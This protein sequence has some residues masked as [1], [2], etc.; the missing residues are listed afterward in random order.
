MEKSMQKHNN[1]DGKE[2]FFGSIKGKII[3]M[4][5]IAVVAS[6]VSGYVGM[7]SLN[8]NSSNNEMLT[9]I[10]R[11][12]LYQ[13]ENKSFD[14]SYLYFLED[15]YLES[16]INNLGKMEELSG[17]A[18]ENS[19][20]S[21][22]EYISSMSDT[23]SS[24]KKNYVDIR[25]LSS[26]RGFDGASG[27]YAE[28]LSQDED[29][30]NAYIQI[31]DDKSWVD[32]SWKKLSDGGKSV[33]VDGK[34]YFKYT[35]N[36]EIPAIG[37]RENFLARIG[38]TGIE[39]NG[40]MYINNINFYKGR[41]KEEAD[42]AGMGRDAL[43]GSYGDALKEMEITQFSGKDT[44]FVKSRF[45]KANASWEEVSLKLPMSDFNMQDYERLSFDIYIEAA[46]GRGLTA[47]C[48][49]ADKYGFK[50]ALSH[51][52]S[53]T[54]SYSKHVVEGSA[55]EEEVQYVTDI[56]N[57][58]ITNLG[59]YVTDN[60]LKNNILE[61]TNA[62]LAVFNQ[63]AEKD[64]KV[65]GL[66][67]ENIQLSDELTAYTDEIRG[68]I[69]KNTDES[70]SRLL[71][72]ILL[73]LIAGAAVLVFIT[74]YISHSINKSITG[75][76]NVLSD[77]MAGN[78]GVRA[79]ETGRDEFSVFGKYLNE[80][81]NKI[82]EVIHVTQKIS[83]EV[84]KSGDVLG[85][86]AEGSNIT[87]TGI[88]RAVSDISGGAQTQAR[89]VETASMHIED[90]GNV[91]GSIAG[92]V[93]HLGDVT[94]KM[95][96]ISDESS[97][98]M[99]ELSEANKKTSGAFSKVVQQIYLTNDSV[100][101]I[102]EAT[103]F[104]TSIAE[105]TNLL[106][107]NAS[108]EAARAGEAGKGFAVVATEI[109]QLAAQSST[110]ASN[111]REIIEDLV[112][113]A[114]QTV[115]IVDEVSEIITR[116]QEKLEQTSGHFDFLEEGIANS[117]KEMEQIRK[118]TVICEKARKK[119]EEVIVGLSAISE[120]NAASAEQTAASMTG[121]K[122]T[123]SNLVITSKE[124]NNLADELDNSLRFFKVV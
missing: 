117:S 96:K 41:S 91:F 44:V 68:I 121:L 69:E 48:A 27:Q 2:S 7:A 25:S 123:I 61:K 46:N 108:I 116:Q 122:G 104:I 63:M 119:V 82:S 87:S 37:K 36:S 8:K 75:F 40:N 38:G 107:L 77:V 60:N 118:S 56:F 10:N 80:F 3:L 9:D 4:G 72:V 85:N 112:Q 5:V 11:I 6:C 12:N 101:K 34:R 14:T 124:L 83:E 50:E 20:A 64:K 19:S 74:L 52:N 17:S 113:K 99:D 31:Q 120:Q 30:R 97:L 13:Y 105:Q 43:S 47:A 57:E 71:A 35:Y 29:I 102:R 109:S 78:L 86:M 53:K 24:C 111:I 39:Y 65:L 21:A 94:G 26:E 95:K 54:A 76:K 23:I 51:I 84:K 16:I 59:Y 18:K 70:K 67:A 88:S 32:G 93:E 1:G 62:K 92:N 81:L 110:S 79:K 114:G 15:Q 98:L 55:A 115:N 100:K 22:K 58:V 103:E 28:F 49:F 73:V 45:T 89:E 33:S 66:K 42:I 90:M 106:S